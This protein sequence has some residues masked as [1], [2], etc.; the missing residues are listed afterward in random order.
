[1]Y[2]LCFY[3]PES[4]VEAVKLAVF[5]AGAG[6]IGEYDS[7]C[8]Q[9]LGKSDFTRSDVVL[10]LGGGAVT[11]LAGFIASVYH[12]GIPV[13]HCSTTLLKSARNGT[14]SLSSNKLLTLI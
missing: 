7:C 14:M 5:T 2:K 8:W 1:M 9:V 6:R 10:G 12:R 13:V 4:H 11:D 3:V